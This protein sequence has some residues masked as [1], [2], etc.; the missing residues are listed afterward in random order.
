MLEE[1]VNEAVPAK[2]AEVV[3]RRRRAPLGQ[4]E[5]EVTEIED[6]DALAFTAEVDVRPKI[7][8]PALNELA[9]QPSTT[10]R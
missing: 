8:L 6:G 4:P 10:S 7:E 2:Y 9:V 5:I 3:T 1:V